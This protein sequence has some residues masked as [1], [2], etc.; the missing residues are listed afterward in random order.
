MSGNR[1][2]VEALL[3]RGVNVNDSTDIN[4]SPL[5]LVAAYGYVEIAKDL[6]AAGANI[7]AE[8]DPAGEHPL[9]VSADAGNTRIVQ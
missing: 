2:K 5:L 7:E 8:G 6:I 1:T 3:A 4:G 9:H